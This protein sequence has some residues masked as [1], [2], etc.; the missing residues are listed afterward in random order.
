VS[1]TLFRSLF[2][3]DPR[4]AGEVEDE[5]RAE[6][7]S[8]VAMIEEEL[9]RNGADPVAAREQAAAR[10]GDIGKLVREG[11]NIKLGDRIM[12]QRINLALLIVLG[13]AVIWLLVQNQRISSR[14]VQTLEQV[15][16]SLASMEQA[17][18]A[19]RQVIIAEEARRSEPPTKLVY[20]KGHVARP[21]PIAIPPGGLTMRR[22]IESAGGLKKGATTIFLDHDQPG[23]ADY[24]FAAMDY[25]GT[26][27]PDPSLESNDVIN[28][29]HYDLP[30]SEPDWMQNPEHAINDSAKADKT[31]ADLLLSRQSAYNSVRYLISHGFAAEHRNVRQ[32]VVTVEKIDKQIETRISELNSTAK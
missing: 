4:P 31:L 8:H 28:V 29:V 24:E 21:G 16:A 25:L 14:S 18:S 15:S 11:R 30:I 32:A 26:H 23:I 2:I 19:E 9:I 5:V 12:L 20:V 1:R 27:R 3:F 7:E 6:F 13:T 22:A 17:R 10:F